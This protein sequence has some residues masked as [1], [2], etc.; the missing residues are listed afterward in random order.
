V[1]DKKTLK[2]TF[3]K[4]TH[5]GRFWSAAG[6]VFF[7]L[8]WF[9]VSKIFNSSLILPSPLQTAEALPVVLTS[10]AFYKKV[11][12]TLLRIIT[13]FVIALIAGSVLAVL[14]LR[15]RF[16][17][18][19]RP[20]ISFFRSIPT[21]VLTVLILSWFG[22]NNSPTFIGIL[23]V[24]PVVYLGLF[25]ALNNVDKN[26]LEMAKIYKVP[27]SKIISKIYFQSTL[28][29]V[30]STATTAFGMI[31]KVV[32]SAEVL[33]FPV[34]SIGRAI[35][36]QQQLLNIPEVFAWVAVVLVLSFIFETVINI[37]QR[38]VIRWNR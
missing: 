9:I 34:L 17:E 24:F 27:Q 16:E 7:I 30:F 20:I 38:F 4:I 28:P 15:R 19:L 12:A 1:T 2:T 31:F 11:L 22:D 23:T 33:I 8:L 21:L 10:Q 26:L 36:Y 37:I 6:V 35:F 13:A 14:S 29:Y 32:V 25:T 5:S 3:K 18:F